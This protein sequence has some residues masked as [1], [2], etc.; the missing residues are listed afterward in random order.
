MLM[1]FLDILSNTIIVLSSDNGGQASNGGASNGLLRGQ[2]NTYF[3]GGIRVP[4]FAYSPL[5]DSYYSNGR[6]SDW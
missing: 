6:T 1:D 4:S 2:K 3:E 5:F